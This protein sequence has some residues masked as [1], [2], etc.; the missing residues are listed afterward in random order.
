MH[1]AASA[2]LAVDPSGV[3]PAVV[4][5][6]Q[7][8]PHPTRRPP[9]ANRPTSWR[10]SSSRASRPSTRTSACSISPYVH[11]GGKTVA[12]ALKE[13]EGK[14]GGPIKVTGFYRFRPRRGI[15]KEEAT[16]PPK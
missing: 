13:A 9:R 11:D 5:R 15:E 3:D 6:E 10:R 2:P 16:S 14:T 1:I 4:E 8:V 7:A 12:Q